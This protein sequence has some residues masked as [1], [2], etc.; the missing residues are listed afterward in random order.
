[1][2]YIC[3]VCHKKMRRRFRNPDLS[4]PY[5]KAL[6]EVNIT[7]LPSIPLAP[8]PRKEDADAFVKMISD[9]LFLEEYIIQLGGTVLCPIKTPIPNLIRKAKEVMSS[10]EEGFQLYTDET[11]KEFHLL[12]VE[13]LRDFGEALDNLAQN[14]PGS[15]EFQKALGALYRS[16]YVLL[17]ISRGLAF[18]MHVNSIIGRLAQALNLPEM[19]SPNSTDADTEINYIRN[20]VLPKSFITWLRLMVGHFD[21]MEVL[22]KFATSPAFRFTEI[23]ASFMVVEEPDAELLPW[24]DLFDRKFLPEPEVAK[25]D[26]D[27]EDSDKKNKNKEVNVTN[28]TIRQFL[29]NKIKDAMFAKTML[30]H[31][32]NLLKHLKSFDTNFVTRWVKNIEKAI[33]TR[34]K[35]LDAQSKALSATV[36]AKETAPDNAGSQPELLKASPQT[37]DNLTEETAPDDAGYQLGVLE[38]ILQTVDNLKEETAPDDAGSQLELLKTSLHT[39]IDLATEFMNVK[40]KMTA[41]AADLN[42]T[43]ETWIKTQIKANAAHQIFYAIGTKKFLQGTLHCEAYLAS[44]LPLHMTSPRPALLGVAKHLEVKPF[45]CLFLPSNSKISVYVAISRAGNRRIQ[46]LLPCLPLLPRNHPGQKSKQK[47]PCARFA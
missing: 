45:F 28:D 46:T 34:T 44:F 27:K 26:S 13:T 7:G 20:L 29:D 17:R 30:D 15:V 32:Q 24:R 36:E 41:A 40:E 6:E 37:V 9:R 47:I 35:E 16:G 42:E 2:M 43:V 21:S 5:L 4:Q 1:M 12:L 14:L 23:S 22:I 38:A 25:K 19:R 33:D 10:E 8:F 31:S 18:Q 11:R 3:A 39:V